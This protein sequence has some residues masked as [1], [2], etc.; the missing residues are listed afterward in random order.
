MNFNSVIQKR[1]YMFIRAVTSNWISGGKRQMIF[2]STMHGPYNEN[3]TALVFLI[4]L[5]Y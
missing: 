4:V 3:E 5:E 1:D 2:L